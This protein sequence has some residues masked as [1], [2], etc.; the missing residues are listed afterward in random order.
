MLFI[1]VL[2]GAVD[3]PSQTK[4]NNA[5]PWYYKLAR[6][7]GV[8][9]APV[10]LKGPVS[11]SPGE[12]WIVP[13]DRVEPRR[14]TDGGDFSSPVFQPGGKYVFALRG[15]TLVRI[16]AAGGTADAVQTI[17]GVIKLV[18]FDTGNPDMV[19]ALF[20]AGEAG[21]DRRLDIALLSVKT[22]KRQ[23]IAKAQSAD[24]EEVE[25]LLGWQRQY[26]KIFVRPQGGEIAAGGI[27]AVE[28]AVTDCRDASCGQPAYSPELR[29]IA[30]IRTPR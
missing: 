5:E 25:S 27:G 28:R 21:N 4:K 19:L 23:V 29:E 12:L 8:N 2:A 3:G 18:G 13:I 30:F 17:P 7:L 10:A 14:L 6:I 22:A 15:V 1:L 11:A 20:D 9:R 24:D 26:G 16:P